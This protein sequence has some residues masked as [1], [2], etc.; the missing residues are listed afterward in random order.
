MLRK[1]SLW[2]AALSLA[3]SVTFVPVESSAG[4]YFGPRYGTI[5]VLYAGAYYGGMFVPA[6]PFGHL[7]EYRAWD[8][9]CA[10]LRRVVFTPRGPQSQLVPVCF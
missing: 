9:S 1:S 2:L 8:P 6:G 3:A 7:H 5:P 4:G 10:F